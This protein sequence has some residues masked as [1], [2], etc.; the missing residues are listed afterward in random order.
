MSGCSRRICLLL[1]WLC[2]NN[3][4]PCGC[5]AVFLLDVNSGSF[6][7]S[8]GS[9]IP[10]LV[11][12]F[13]HLQNQPYQPTSYSSCHLSGPDLPLLLEKDF[14]II[15]PLQVIQDDFFILK[16]PNDVLSAAQSP[17]CPI[18]HTT[19]SQLP[20]TGAWTFSGG[21]SFCQP[22]HMSPLRGS[23]GVVSLKAFNK[24]IFLKI[25]RYVDYQ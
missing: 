1:I 25:S 14:V 15:V 20:Q 9:C 19:N 3:S 17:P 21:L 4:V 11:A 13:L 23:P 22:Q 10:W 16:S 2:W 24:F 18:T 5:R 8:R 7:T 12:P 6:P